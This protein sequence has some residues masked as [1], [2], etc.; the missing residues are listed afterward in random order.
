[1]EVVSAEVAAPLAEAAHR[2]RA[3]VI[4]IKM[5]ETTWAFFLV[6]KEEPA[7]VLQAL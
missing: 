7:W 5:E 1:L 2:D 6:N 4:N 3:L